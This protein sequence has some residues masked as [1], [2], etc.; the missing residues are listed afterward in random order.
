MPSFRAI[1]AFGAAVTLAL[2]WAAKAAAQPAGLPKRVAEREDEALAA[3]ANY[4][5]KQEVVVEELDPK[6]RGHYK[7]TRAIIFSPAGERSEK[8]IGQPVS[9]L[10]R[11][12]LT[13]EDFRDIRD[14]QPQRRE[15]RIHPRAIA[16]Q[17]QDRD[18]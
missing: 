3:R 2:A 13:E 5:Y 4:T 17:L 18:D 1:A 15:Q 8:F 12:R 9:N 10:K 7:E 11:L 6:G 14:I 16:R